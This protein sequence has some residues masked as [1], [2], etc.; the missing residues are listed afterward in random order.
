MVKMVDALVYDSLIILFVN[1]KN[2][3]TKKLIKKQ[4]NVF[5]LLKEVNIKKQYK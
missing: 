1:N 3:F 4:I 5:V 2:V